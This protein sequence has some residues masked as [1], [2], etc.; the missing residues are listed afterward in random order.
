MQGT[1]LKNR[2]SKNNYILVSK[3]D[4]GT[5]ISKNSSAFKWDHKTVRYRYHYLPR[6]R[7]H[8]LPRYRYPGIGI[9]FHNPFFLSRYSRFWGKRNHL[10]YV[11]DSRMRQLYTATR[12]AAPQ[13]YLLCYYY[14]VSWGIA[15]PPGQ[16]PHSH[17]V[18]LY[19]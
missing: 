15:Q 11:G 16:Q 8:Y 7:Y 19:G 2:K 5:H 9:V 10:V 18:L 12:S 17:I 13:P 6:Y 4:T 14:W 1:L 3:K